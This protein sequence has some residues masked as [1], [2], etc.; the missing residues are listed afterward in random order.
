MN[1]IIWYEIDKDFWCETKYLSGIIEILNKEIN[2][3]SIIITPNL[4]KLPKSTYRKIVILTGDELGRL[5]NPPYPGEDVFA[6][7]R[8]YNRNGRFDNNLIYPIPCGYNWTMHN[9]P[10]KK[11]IKMYP[12]KP[13]SKRRHDL[14]FSGQPVPLRF[15]MMSALQKLNHS[16]FNILSQMNKSFRTGI[17]IDDYYK[18]LG[19][20]KISLA[21]DGTSV[22]TFRYVESFGSGCIVISTPKDNLWYYMNAPTI[23]IPNWSYLNDDLI[24]QILSGD[25]DELYN[26]NLEYYQNSL[27]EKAVANYMM[28]IIFGKLKQK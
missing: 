22:D 8:I 21:P 25:I 26:R 14:F 7:F 4:F 2:E 1:E 28:N 11:M 10:S 20:T 6:I 27:S 18:I 9:D 24:N 12:E 16:S 3:F 5:P 13:I 15:E 17:N 19:E 23:V